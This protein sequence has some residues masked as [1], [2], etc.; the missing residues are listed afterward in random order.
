MPDFV[1]VFVFLDYFINVDKYYELV[2]YPI[3]YAS[4]SLVGVLALSYF[5]AL[6]FDEKL[7]PFESKIVEISKKNSKFYT[8]QQKWIE[9]LRSPLFLLVLGG[10]FHLLLDTGMWP[11]AGGI[12]WLYP[13]NLA[14]FE[15]SFKLWWPST[16]DAMII[17]APILAISLCSYCVIKYYNSKKQQ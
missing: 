7:K 9:K 16:P 15:W 10:L 13:L 2:A 14:P 1:R 17:L 3:N 5:L 4:H 8:F 6:F 12:N 11:W